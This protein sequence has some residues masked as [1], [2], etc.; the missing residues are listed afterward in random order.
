MEQK[1]SSFNDCHPEASALCP[2]TDPSEPRCV[3]FFATPKSRV[4]LAS[5]IR[6]HVTGRMLLRNRISN[7]VLL[8][9]VRQPVKPQIHHRR[10]VEREQ[11]A[12]QQ[13]ANNRD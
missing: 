8:K 13:T 2:P 7:L 10:R 5:L 4:W 6:R 11:L 3:A 1:C 9:P 12:Q